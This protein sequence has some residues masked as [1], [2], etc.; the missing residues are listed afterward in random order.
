MHRQKKEP[1]RG[2]ARR[3]QRRN[4]RIWRNCVSVMACVVVFCVTYAL[5]IPAITMEKEAFCGIEAHVHEES[6]YNST[7]VTLVCDPA[8][9][10]GLPVLHTHD[11]LCYEGETL[12][13]TLPELAGHVHTEACYETVTTE[14][15]SHD[16]TCKGLVRGA[17]LCEISEDVGHTH[18][19]T[20]YAVG[21]KLVCTEAV[22]EGHT[23]SDDCYLAETML[24]CTTAEGEGH[25]HSDACYQTE[26]VLTCVTAESEGHSHGESCKDAEGNLICTL[27]EAPAHTHGDGCYTENKTLICEIPEAP[28]HTHGEDCYTENKT[29][30]CEIPEDPG[31]AHT[32]ACYEQVLVCGQEEREGHAHTDA[33]YEMVEGIVCGKEET[34]A[35]TVTNLV[36]TLQQVAP[37]VHNESCSDEN[38]NLICT[39]QNA[40][41]HQHTEACL[42]I[43]ETEENLIC[44]IPVHEHT[45]SCFS[46]PQADVETAEDWTKTFAHVELTGNWGEDV[47]AIAKSQLGYNESTKNYIVEEDGETMKGYT[48]YGAWYGVPYGDWCAMYAS[49]CYRYA[50]VEGVP[51]HCNCPAWINEL[52]NL[53]LFHGEED[54]IPNPG[55]LIFFDWNA[56]GSSDH[57][58]IVVETDGDTLKTIE[59]NSGDTVGYHTYN[60]TDHTIQGYGALPVQEAEEVNPYL[61]GFEEHAHT[62]QCYDAEGNLT[63][64]LEEHA[65]TEDCLGKKLFYTDNF[66]RA[67]VTIKGVTDL[68]EDLSVQ[69]W[70]I[71]AEEDPDAFAG[72][73]NALIDQMATDSQFVSGAGFYGMELLSDGEVYELPETAE[74]TVE[75]EFMEPLFTSEEVEDAAQIQT[76]MLT[77]QETAAPEETDPEEKPEAAARSNMGIAVMSLFSGGTSEEE[78]AEPAAYDAQVISGENYEE[79]DVGLTA[80]SFQSNQIATF[81]VARATTVQEGTFWTRVTTPAELASGGT[82]MIVSAEGNY[83]LRGNSTTNYQAVDVTAVKSH[84]EYYTISGSDD[85]MLRW[86]FSGSGSTYTIRCQGTNQRYLRLSDSTFISSTS[87]NTTVSYH[88]PENCWRLYYNRSYQNDYYLRNSGDSF[89]RTSDEYDG[90]FAKRNVNNQY[91]Y[92]YYTRDMLIFKLSDVKKLDIP[93]DVLKETEESGSTQSGP[94]KPA[95]GEFITPSTQQTGDTFVTDSQS[96][97][98]NVAGKYY[99]D[100]ATSDIEAGFR[101]VDTEKKTARTYAQHELLDGKVVTDKSVIYGK[102]DYSAFNNYPANTFGV[103]LSA[104]GQEYEVPYQYIVKTP[105]DVVFILDVSGSMA[106]EGDDGRDAS[107]ADAVTKAVNASMKQ[108]LEKHTENRVGIVLY[109]SG[110]WKMLPLDRYTATRLDDNGNPEYLV[111]KEQTITHQPTNYKPTVRRILGGS[112]LTNDEGVSYANAGN[113][114]VQGI[115]TYPQAGIALANELFE[116]IGDDTTYT[117]TMGEGD[118]TMTQTVKRQPVFIL[119]SDG[120]PTH[121]TNNYM[122]P[123]SGPHY[124]NGN[125][126]S[127]NAKGIHGYYT[128]LSANY[129]KRQVAIQYDKPA[130]FYTIGMGIN[131]PADGDGPMVDGSDTGDRYK[132]AV[133]NPYPQPAGQETDPEAIENLTSSTNAGVTTTLLKQLMTGTYANDYVTVSYNWPD[134][135]MG[136]PH[137]DVPALQPNP[138]AG[139]YR[140]ADNAYFGSLGSEDLEKI[141]AE[142]LQSSLKETP[143][144]FILFRNSKVD[145]EDT[146]G[147][148]ME[149]KGDPILRYNG[150][151]Y[152][153]TSVVEN[154]DNKTVTYVYSAP[155]ENGMIK[156]PYIPDRTI[157]LSE[158]QVTVTTLDNGQQ[159]VEMMVPDTA[160]PTYTPELEGMNYYYESLP[161]RLIYQVGLTETSQTAV[162]NLAKT[163]GELIYYTNDWD[164]ADRATAVLHPSLVNPF[165]HEQVDDKGQVI[166]SPHYYAH[167][168]L[169]DDNTTDTEEYFIDCTLRSYNVTD[170]DGNPEEAIE[171][172]HLQG[173]NGKLVFTAEKPDLDIPV[174]KQWVNVNPDTQDPVTFT[175]YKVT[176]SGNSASATVESTLELNAANNWT[177]TFQE[178]MLPENDWYYAIGEAV[179]TGFVVTYNGETLTA[180]VGEGDT[181][182]Y[183]T[184]VKVVITDGAAQKVT[185]KNAPTITLPETGGPG[186]ILYTT[187]GLLLMMTAAYLL[188][189]QSK[190]RRKGEHLSF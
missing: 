8:G 168:D 145:I 38:G 152:T 91:V 86:T 141:F 184:M 136:V 52:T 34:E 112:T 36:C 157:N 5:I 170:A 44:E 27:P 96:G 114:A 62:E 46:N 118:T 94:P 66:V 4:R 100:P 39:I 165:Y 79:S 134:S 9:E 140:Y 55:E 180:R 106:T 77:P 76:F 187:G 2:E 179:P 6:C 89:E 185:I 161:V 61:C 146:I 147:E 97:G 68:P 178:L 154:K 42:Q 98:V 174:E 156:D 167:H 149:I 23:H 120:E 14:A 81:A 1:V 176:E 78:S 67:F 13:C 107:R 175:L 111:C 102:D 11:A 188:H 24:S 56:D 181:A 49:F 105:V 51:L 182:E 33:C 92:T 110:A 108:I 45:L 99:S 31:H 173:N 155:T 75:V 131:T 15:H 189:N 124:G 29:L 64:G 72:M 113:D 119:L 21:E 166:S 159:K 12:I 129:F 16:E 190:K 69:V 37:H 83:A 128:I 80:V 22:R 54:Y 58:G 139:N 183:V 160:L 133:L 84:E 127:S 101:Y 20:C 142:I 171:V 26:K 7:A 60:L 172:I 18:D 130:L 132:R 87:A 35:A 17:L 186:T 153:H 88:T 162:L 30:T 109:S 74:V 28:A 135:W 48:R 3:R 151:N 43:P 41:V 90:Y 115:G 143:Y 59:G 25:A 125:G 150:V 169:K 73:Q 123:I 126:T 57:V 47:L 95:Y 82:F 85:T 32:D 10:E 158:I 116:A 164:A 53:G 163:G 71:T 122:D 93:A 137:E 40:V 104:L 138:Y 70:E 117:A 103:T 144:G 63:C 50:A 121:S 19:S 65:H 148:G 177:G